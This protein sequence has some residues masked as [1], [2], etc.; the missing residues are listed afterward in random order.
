MFISLFTLSPARTQS[1]NI[2]PVADAGLSRYAAQDPI[3]L[4][5]TGSYDPD[6]PGLLSFSWKQISGLPV[7]IID[8]NTVTPTIAGYMVPGSRRDRTPKPGDFTQTDEIK[9]CEFE[10]VVNDGELTSHPD[11]VKVIIVPDFGATTLELENP[12]FKPNKPTVIYF[13]GGDCVTGDVGEPWNASAWN[14][15]ANVISFPN[16]YEPDSGEGVYTYYKYG[17]MIIVYLSSVAP[18]YKQPIQTM[19]WSTGGQPAIDVG[20]RLNMTYW[21]ARYAVNHITFL[22]ATGYC[23][24]YSESIKQFLTS[25]VD[26]EQCWIDNY[27]STLT[28]THLSQHLCFHPN[29]LNIGF[30]VMSHILA[31]EWYAN[32]ITNI[33][34][35]KFNKGVVAGAYWS[36]IGPGKNLQLAST[37]NAQIYKFKWS[38][39]ATAGYMDFYDEPNH[40]DRL[41][42]P[43]TLVGPV[44]TENHNGFILTCEESENAVNYQLLFGLDPDRVMDYNIISDTPAPPNDIITTLPFNDGWW[45]VR[46]RDEYGSTICADPIYLSIFV[47]KP[48]PADGVMH[49]D[50]WATLS[51][52]E[53]IRSTSYDVYFGETFVDV[54]DG[55]AE[56]FQ[57]NQTSTYF[58]IGF[59][60]FPYPNGLVPGTTYFW[61]IDDIGADGT[62]INKGK[63][64]SFTVPP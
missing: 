32:S 40:P 12:P 29:V 39:S 62:V 30:E 51:W 58:V 42:E 3:I 23:R 28:G 11:I 49:P 34:T 35:N 38:G 55:S 13:G 10:L 4:D 43:V 57:G 48:K 22:D 5:G 17:D 45:T 14:N 61:R 36:V 8:A 47:S 19:G 31:Q 18:D 1:Q 2:R 44:L 26:V 37:P 24:D 41:P 9:E 25:S 20:L 63:I 64:W 21:D 46:V 50:T 6:D 53:G 15:R 54:Q 56:V 7:I 60:G 33:D 59:A 52:T 27:S 16:G